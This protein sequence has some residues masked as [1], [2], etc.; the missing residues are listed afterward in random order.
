MSPV[1]TAVDYFSL[2]RSFLIG[3]STP[4]LEA[5]R[6]VVGFN[7]HRDHMPEGTVMEEPYLISLLLPGS[8]QPANLKGRVVQTQME[9][10]CYGANPRDRTDLENSVTLEMLLT[11]ALADVKD[12]TVTGGVIMGAMKTGPGK[13]IFDPDT[14]RPFQRS[15][16][17]AAFS[18][19][20]PT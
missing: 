18:I 6:T 19:S 4:A 15:V 11:D 5:L 1:A 7:I 3:K 2:L 12:E 10:W 16:W 9:I 8:S 20:K 17:R 14:R 13:G